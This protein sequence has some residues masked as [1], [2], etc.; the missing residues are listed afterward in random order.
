L[1][2]NDLVIE[3]TSADRKLLHFS[4][5]IMNAG[6]GVLELLGNLN[7]AAGVTVF[8]QHVYRADGTFE[9]FPSGKIIFHI[10]H[11]HWHFENF[12]RYE[13]W[14]L[15]P[16]GD[17]DAVVVLSDKVS[18]CIRDDRRANIPGAAAQPLFTDCEQALQGMSPGWIDIYAFDTPGQ[19][20]DMTGLPDGVYA[21]RSTV[22]PAGQ[23]VESDPT[24]NAG[25]VYFEVR[26]DR[27]RVLDSGVD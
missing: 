25:L 1:S 3:F 17:L 13:V 2:P 26:G 6:P 22:D 11:D 8:T 15:T 14:S 23:I 5:Y 24:N 9:E 12:A 16:A 27:V 10:G 18:Y 4:N 20:I 19:T 7:P 21:L